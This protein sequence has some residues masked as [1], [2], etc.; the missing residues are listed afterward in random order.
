M[1]SDSQ[2]VIEGAIVLNKDDKQINKAE[3]ENQQ[4]EEGNIERFVI[5]CLTKPNTQLF[6][7][8]TARSSFSPSPPS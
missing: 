8:L 5:K 4:N 7:N 1:I 6:H 3:M 2:G